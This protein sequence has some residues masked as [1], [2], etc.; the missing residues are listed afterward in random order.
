M[1][2]EDQKKALIRKRDKIKNNPF[3]QTQTQTQSQ[4]QKESQITDEKE[5]APLSQGLPTDGS[6]VDAEQAVPQPIRLVDLDLVPDAI[7]IKDEWEW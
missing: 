6:T 3:V 2:E 1:S 4:L 7:D 5:N